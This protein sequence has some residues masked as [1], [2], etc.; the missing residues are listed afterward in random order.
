MLPWHQEH[1]LLGHSLKF[2]EQ[3][4]ERQNCFDLQEHKTRRGCEFLKDTYAIHQPVEP[5]MVPCPS[6]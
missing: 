4:G 1:W 6:S 5:L 3:A 2:K